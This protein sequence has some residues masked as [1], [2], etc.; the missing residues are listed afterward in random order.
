MTRA[1]RLE[2]VVNM[3][4]SFEIHRQARL[5]CALSLLVGWSAC[6]GGSGDDAAGDGGTGECEGTACAALLLRDIAPGAPDPSPSSYPSRLT[7]V[8]STTFFTARDDLNGLELWKTDGTASGTEL[9]KD[10]TIG[11]DDSDFGELVAVG[12]T[13]YFAVDDAVH[14]MELWRSDGTAEGT[15][16]VR[17]IRP[18]EEGASPTRLTAVGS[19]LFFSAIEPASG[20]RRLH[21][22]D[23]TAAGTYALPVRLPDFLTEMNGKLFCHGDAIDV[24]VALRLWVSDGTLDGTKKIAF[25]PDT[26]V[27]V[28]P[29]NLHVHQGKLYFLG[30]PGS[31]TGWSVGR[32]DLYVSGGDPSGSDTERL[33]VDRF[34]PEIQGAWASLGSTLVFAAREYDGTVGGGGAKLWQRE[35]GAAPARV[36]LPGDDPTSPEPRDLVEAGGA[37]YFTAR[38]AEAGTARHVMRYD[39]E[40]VVDL[41]WSPLASDPIL[42]RVRGERVSFFTHAGAGTASHA[43]LWETDGTVAG[44]QPVKTIHDHVS[45]ASVTEAV[46]MGSALYFPADNGVSG[47]ELW[48][49]D[50]TEAGTH[51]LADVHVLHQA[52][53]PSELV[54]LGD[55]LLFAASELPSVEGADRELWTSD[56]TPAGTRRLVDIWPGNGGSN[57]RYLT[58]VGDRVYFAANDGTGA[59]PWLT[60]GTA[61]GTRMLKDIQPGG[62]SDPHDFVV[63][64]GIVFF[65][66]TD[67]AH[68]QELWKT[69][70]TEEGTVR[71]KDIAPGASSSSPR[72][73][74]P[75]GGKLIFSATDPEAGRELW[76]SDGTEGGTQRLSDVHPGDAGSAPEPL[77]VYEGELYFVATRPLDGRELWKT[78]GTPGGTTRVRDINPD[79]AS[80][81]PSD[82]LVWRARLYFVAT[83]E[84]EGRELWS[85]DGTA[86]GT[87]IVR[88][89]FV[90]GSSDPRS[91]TVSADSLF[92]RARDAGD[93]HELWKTDG[94]AAGTA[95]VRDICVGGKASWANALIDL[96]GLLVFAADDCEHG[97]EVWVSDGTHDGTRLLR[98]IWA[99]PWPSV[100]YTWGGGPGPGATPLL[101][102]ASNGIDGA[103]LWRT[104]GTTG[105]TRLVHEFARGAG[106]F[107][108]SAATV[109]V[110]DRVFL[111]VDDGEHGRELWTIPLAGL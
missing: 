30:Q 46:V 29:R 57:P 13:L 78:D 4:R 81:E 25:T 63:S 64:D 44:T 32:A 36:S 34:H 48:T 88:N 54:P 74:F 1:K 93:D 55:L 91:L 26:S 76:V 106:S 50:G 100:Y 58:R 98:D 67:S 73:L 43:V 110:G 69:D 96:D 27:R 99:G 28:R 101:F 102:Q 41:H 16:L 52:S 45:G 47:V 8:G 68:G 71:V 75:F 82:A 49:S 104:D 5:A 62:G 109:T 51:L 80:S 14:G 15:V 83:T 90:G 39:L 9:V 92:F 3:Y 95:R 60:D 31:E 94:T 21:V 11:S 24:D 105:G 85:T 108:M 2:V 42:L 77:A 10:L 107:E 35:Q 56:G 84:N 18:G 38:A 53:S 22:S 61:A 79:A 33:T 66:A 6:G 17:D 12:D 19:K 20:E 37:L 70:G 72:H 89:I 65:V 86:A 87:Q 40:E 97:E 103:E 59:E 111:V 7:V 23:G